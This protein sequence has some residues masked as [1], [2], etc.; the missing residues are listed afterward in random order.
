[1][2]SVLD[3]T[4]NEHITKKVNDE[5]K[6]QHVQGLLYIEPEHMMSQIKRRPNSAGR[7]IL[8]QVK[9]PRELT[10]PDDDSSGITEVWESATTWM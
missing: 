7:T 5:G 2:E 8:A 6:H 9:S 10:A 1:M 3:K 4:I